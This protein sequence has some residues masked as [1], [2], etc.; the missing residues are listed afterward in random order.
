VLA[1]GGEFFVP[2]FAVGKQTRILWSHNFDYEVYLKVRKQ[3]AKKDN[4]IVVFLD[5]SFPFHPDAFAHQILAVEQY[6]PRLCRFFDHLE[7]NNGIHIVIAAHPRSQY[8]TNESL[9]G[10]RTVIRGKTA[11]LVNE[12]RVVIL[13]DSASINYAVLFKKPMI[14]ITTDMLK[15]ARM[16]LTEFMAA[17]FDKK[18][19][20]IDHS[21][22]IDLNS[23]LS[24]NDKL[25]EQYKNRY[26]KKA[27]T[28]DAS[29]WQVF[30]DWLKK[31]NAIGVQ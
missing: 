16:G 23:E 29:A 18:V 11:E 1:L 12:S 4:K 19:F 30:A 8:E 20:N 27:E 17:L 6:Y 13:H 10:N 3:P 7:K 5:Q 22:E 31:Q 21:F 24:V 9:W 26:I 15:E 28:D 25:Y 2:K 14:F